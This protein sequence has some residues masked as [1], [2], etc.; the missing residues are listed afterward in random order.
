MQHA[1][2]HLRD[3]ASVDEPAASAHLGD[4]CAGARKHARALAC[5]QDGRLRGVVAVRVVI[6][7]TTGWCCS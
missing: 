5:W 7:V 2:N 4:N 6:P 3:L 1:L